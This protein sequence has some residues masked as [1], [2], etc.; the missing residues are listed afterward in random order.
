MNC[1]VDSSFEFT[2]SDK[3]KTL[4]KMMLL[5]TKKIDHFSTVFTECFSHFNSLTPTK[6]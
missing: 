1:H 2:V 6:Q 4:L 5:K 3:F